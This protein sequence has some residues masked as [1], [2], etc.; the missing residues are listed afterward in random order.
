MCDVSVLVRKIVSDQDVVEYE[1]VLRLQCLRCKQC[2]YIMRIKYSVDSSCLAMYFVVKFM[3]L[4][5]CV[6]LLVEYRSPVDQWQSNI[7]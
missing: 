7:V 4:F 6:S 2:L 5:L 3:N 1:L